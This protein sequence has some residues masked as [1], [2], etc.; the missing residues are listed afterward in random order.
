MASIL[1][2]PLGIRQTGAAAILLLGS[3]ATITAAQLFEHV[4][5]YLP[6]ELCLLQRWPYYI[7]VP[8]ALIALVTA[9]G[10]MPAVLP[11]ALLTLIG[12]LM[13]FGLGTAVYHAGV[14]WH[15]WAGPTA[16]TTGAETDMSGDLLATMD[17]VKPVA[18]DQ[19]SWRF[20]GLSFAGWNV[21]ASAFF[22]LVAF[23]GAFGRPDRV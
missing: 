9:M 18:C 23:R 10:R 13:L 14:E 20:L 2:R 6:C 19:A 22:A 7:S 11:R 12:L 15:F 4:G 17:A 1:S 5:G 21:L 3:A 8:L 16:C